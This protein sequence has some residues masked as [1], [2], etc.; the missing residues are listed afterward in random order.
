MS[1]QPTYQFRVRAQREIAHRHAAE[2]LEFMNAERESVG[3]DPVE[4]DGVT[5]AGAGKIPAGLAKA[6]KAEVAAAKKAAKK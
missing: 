5:K 2:Y 1:Y 3:L 4:A 6:S